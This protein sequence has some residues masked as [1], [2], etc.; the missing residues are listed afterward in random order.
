VTVVSDHSTMRRSL[1]VVAVLIAWTS[2]SACYTGPLPTQYAALAVIGGRPTAVVAVCGRSTVYVNLY[3]DDDTMDGELHLWS[4][5]VTP[6]AGASDVDVELLGAARTGWEIT[7]T[8]EP[9]IGSSPGGF[10]VVPLTSIE[11]RHRYTLDSSASGPEGSRAPTVKFTT[12][13][14][15][16]IGAGQ[17]LT[18]VEGKP[19]E[20]VSRDSFVHGRCG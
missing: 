18:A 7:T 15:P 14:L 6:S 5:T 4:V 12:D 16:G 2:L 13:D 11:P 3:L 8:G 17:V 9:T 1:A 10:K 19:A 20:V